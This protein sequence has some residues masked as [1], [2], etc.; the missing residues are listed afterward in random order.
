MIPLGRSILAS[1]FVTAVALGARGD[2]LPSATTSP[3]AISSPDF[4]GDSRPILTMGGNFA[5]VMVTACQE[6]TRQYHV[7]CSDKSIVGGKIAIFD[8]GDHY[9]VLFLHEPP[10]TLDDFYAEPVY[11]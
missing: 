7:A 3:V 10:R 2:P 11:K 8:R 1:M 4:V 6:L 5:A 9:S